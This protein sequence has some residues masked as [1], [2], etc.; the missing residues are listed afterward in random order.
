[1]MKMKI[2]INPQN[3]E[4]EKIK[5]AVTALREGKIILY[6]TDTVY[7]IG[8]NIFNLEAVRKVYSIKKRSLKKPLSICVS[9]IEDIKKVAYLNKDMEKLIVDIFP[10]PYT[11]ILKKKDKISSILTGGQEKIG[12]RV[13]DNEVCM[14]LSREFPITTTS[15]N[16]SGKPVPDSVEGIT[17]QFGGNV[18]LILD[19][20]MCRHGIHSTVIDITV[21]PPKIVRKGVKMP[22]ISN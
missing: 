16:I 12:I 8:A 2:K 13:P 11:V 7:G 14:Q 5:T 18:D 1:M 3:P 15:A 22:P 17:E 20:G 19:A 10:G 4:K 6:P 21:Y 9:K